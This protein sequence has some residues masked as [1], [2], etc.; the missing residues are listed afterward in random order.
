MPTVN[1]GVSA[2]KLKEFDRSTQFVPYAGPQPQSRVVYQW[3]VRR[4][5]YVAATGSKLPQLRVGLELLP[6][7]GSNREARYAGYNVMAFLPVADNTMFRYVPFL[8]A[9]GV[10]EHEFVNK[11][12][13]DH[14]GSVTRI[15]SWRNTGDDVILANL[16]EGQDQAGSPRLEV[17]WMGI[18]RDTEAEAED[19]EY[20]DEE[21]KDEEDDTEDPF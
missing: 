7:E 10:S 21:V 11:T 3:I 2:D 5:R 14:D 1:W 16:K 17:D 6:R 13:I 18:W 19:D 4:L 9:I 8:D 12:I 15:G 20:E